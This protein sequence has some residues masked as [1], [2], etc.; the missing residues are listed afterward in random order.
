MEKLVKAVFLDRD[1]VIN[2]VKTDRVNL[3][4]RPEDFHLLA[5]VPEA[6]AKLRQL[7]F[8]IFVVTNQGGVGLGYITEKTLAKIHQKMRRDLIAQ[9]PEAIID[10]ILYCPHK[11]VA[12]CACRKPR[13]GMILKLAQKY[14]V[15]LSQSWMIGDR[16]T[17]LEAGNRAG[18]Q[19]ILISKDYTLIDFANDL[20]VETVGG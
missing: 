11:P 7:G 9:H 1:G 20:S 15:D 2:E 16:T 5:G 3:V 10:D 18:C 12:G 14:H 19:S 4:N 17:D 13:A 6:I 8:K